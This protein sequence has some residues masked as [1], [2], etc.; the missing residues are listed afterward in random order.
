MPVDGDGSAFLFVPVAERG[1]AAAVHV[2]R[3]V[4]AGVFEKCRV[5]VF[6]LFIGLVPIVIG[7]GAFYLMGD[8]FSFKKAFSSGGP[9]A[10]IPVLLVTAGVFIIVRNAFPKKEDPLS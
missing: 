2:D 3:I 6:D 4:S 9:F 10:L 8:G 5:R 7:V 1:R